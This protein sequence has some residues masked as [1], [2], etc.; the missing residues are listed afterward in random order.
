MN[1]FPID[2]SQYQEL[3]FTEKQQELTADQLERLTSNISLVRECV[4]FASALAGAKGLG[5]HTGGPYNIVPEVLIVEGFLRGGDSVY[6]VCFDEAG[7]RAL[8]H[9]IVSV[10]RGTISADRLLHYR[11]AHAGL[12]GHPELNEELGIA[13]SSGRLG[14]MWAFAN[15]VTRAAG[16]RA[17]VLFGSDGSQQEGSDA[18]AA[19]LAA[20]QDLR[21]KLLIDDNDCTIAGHPGDYLR[22]Y[23]VAQTLA[24]HGVSVDVGDGENISELFRRI[25]AGIRSHSPL[26]LVNRR[27][28][29]PGLPGVEGDPAAHEAISRELAVEYFSARGRSQAVSYLQSVSH[30]ASNR[31]FRGCATEAGSNRKV[32][33]TAVADIVRDIPAARRADSVMVIDCDL[34]GS[35]GIKPIGVEFP[36]VYVKGGVMERGNFSAAAG[37]GF[38]GERQAVFSTYAAFLEMIVSEITMARLNESN[39]LAHFSHAGIDQMAD[40][41]CHYGVNVLLADSGI[42]ELSEQTRLYYPADAYQMRTV[43]DRVFYDRGIRFL[44]SPRVT[45]PAILTEEGSA[46]FDPDQGYSFVPGRDEIVRQGT[47]GYVVSYGETLCRALDAVERLR[48][49][50]IDVGLINKATLNVP[51]E[52]GLKAAAATGLILVVESQNATTGLGARYGSWLLQRGLTP[53]FDFMGT[54]KAGTGGLDEHMLNQGLG[55]LDIRMRIKQLL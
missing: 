26:A 54:T 46:L 6:P 12:Y 18:E 16:D 44:F 29:A 27:K 37:F 11:D 31:F 15:G 10:L 14:H 23:D 25:A 47:T 42:A 45:L 20:A 24:G 2:L 3:R 41:T 30:V 8:I 28:M 13:F 34:E 52:E 50:G 48:E 49:E 22:G 19:R 36:E 38:S 35:T 40:N 55:S 9:Y 1:D 32:F 53:A 39:V 5:G 17:V 51:D 43:V 33:G 7:H 21:I 4:V